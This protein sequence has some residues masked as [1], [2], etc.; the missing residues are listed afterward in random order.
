MERFKIKPEVNSFHCRVNCMTCGT[1]FKPG[2]IGYEFCP[3]DSKEEERG[4]FICPSCAKSEDIKSRIKGKI[5][6]LQEEIDF[7]EKLIDSDIEIP[8]P[9]KMAEVQ[10]EADKRNEEMDLTF[11]EIMLNGKK[12][13]DSD[14]EIVARYK[15]LGHDVIYSFLSDGRMV[16]TCFA[17]EEDKDYNDEVGVFSGKCG[18]ENGEYWSSSQVRKGAQFKTKEEKENY[19]SPFIEI[20]EDVLREKHEELII[21]NQNPTGVKSS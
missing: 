8:T 18:F 20:T 21:R 16:Y 10:K 14:A 2:E 7:M 1:S 13:H 19:L 12:Q 15:L 17:S 6:C 5:H 4:N 9:E 3:S 11:E